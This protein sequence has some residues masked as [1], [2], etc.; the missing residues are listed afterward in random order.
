[1]L[2]ALLHYIQ[3]S[4]VQKQSYPEAFFTLSLSCSYRSSLYNVS[5]SFEQFFLF[6]AVY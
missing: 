4:C 5:S 3:S 1:M 2:L 6:F